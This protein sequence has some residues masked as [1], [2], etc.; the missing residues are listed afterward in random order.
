M[1]GS[2][3]FGVMAMAVMLS[4]ASLA[5]GLIWITTTNPLWLVTAAGR[6]LALVW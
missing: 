1:R 3:W 2:D 4:T 6:L 5:S